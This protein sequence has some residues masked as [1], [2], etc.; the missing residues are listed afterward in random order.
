MKFISW[1]VNGLRACLKKGF[2]EAFSSF[3]ADAVCIQETKMQP[4]QADFAPKATPNTSTAPRR[5]GTPAP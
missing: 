2:A 4:G 5:K 1:N 3:G